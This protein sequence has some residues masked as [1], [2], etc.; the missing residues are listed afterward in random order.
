[1][2]WSEFDFMAKNEVF[3]WAEICQSKAK[4]F[5]KKLVPHRSH[6]KDQPTDSWTWRICR[7][8][9]C[10]P[11]SCRSHSRCWF[12][13]SQQCSFRSENLQPEPRFRQILW[14][15][16]SSRSFPVTGKSPS[17]KIKRKPQKIWKNRNENS[18]IRFLPEPDFSNE[19]TIVKN[20]SGI[21]GERSLLVG[22]QWRLY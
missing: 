17:N 13:G 7:T 18:Y 20:M 15:K 8:S 19:I 12:A 11:S 4:N 16:S 9:Q 21:P 14:L 3:I 6:H 5:K 1:M 22:P 2:S 10:I